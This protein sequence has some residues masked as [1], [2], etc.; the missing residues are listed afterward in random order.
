M[1][2]LNEVL[3]IHQVLIENFG[4]GSGV[5]DLNALKSAINRPFATFDN[6]ELY[7]TP[8]KKAAAL[9]E[10][11]VVNHPFVD[12]NKRIGYVLMRLL[13]LKFRM[14]I[15]AS[16]NEKYLFVIQ[17]ASGKLRTE[18]ILMWLDHHTFN[19]D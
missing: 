10:S 14:D 5:R 16:Q 8:T 13:L 17:I 12:G 1:I 2:E 11:V 18:E 19:L 6:N 4:G 7:P 9:I 3:S 15:T